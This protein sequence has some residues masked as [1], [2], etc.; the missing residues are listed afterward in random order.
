MNQ[1][2]EIIVQN[3]SLKYF[4]TDY[5]LNRPNLMSYP[6]SFTIATSFYSRLWFV[7]RTHNESILR[8]LGLFQFSS[9]WPYE[10]TLSNLI[11]TCLR[12]LSGLFSKL[13]NLETIESLNLVTVTKAKGS[14]TKFDNFNPY[15]GIFQKIVLSKLLL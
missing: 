3:N 1:I 15:F 2:S 11:D 10:K 7:K 14:N 6:L 9:L 4:G 8:P 5:G 13:P 12:G